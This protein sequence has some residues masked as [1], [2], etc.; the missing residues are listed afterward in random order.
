MRKHNC[1]EEMLLSTGKK[2]NQ[3]DIIYQEN[4]G[5]FKIQ[6]IINYRLTIKTTFEVIKAFKINAKNYLQKRK[7]KK[8]NNYHLTLKGLRFYIIK[9]RN[10]KTFFESL[11]I[12]DPQ[13]GSIK[14]TMCSP[15]PPK[16]TPEL[17]LV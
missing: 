5:A 16:P 1:V 11:V 13:P 12:T 4:Q 8:E 2:L 7:E 3:K 15:S 10:C 9:N 14:F 6:A 17:Q